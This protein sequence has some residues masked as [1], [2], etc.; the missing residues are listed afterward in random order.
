[1]SSSRLDDSTVTIPPPRRILSV[2]K[3]DA[4]YQAIRTDI[5]EGRL[6]PGERLR[7]GSLI[8]RLGMSPTP[9]RE[10]LRLL[11]AH[12]LV[13]N[14][15]HHGM[16]VKEYSVA[17]VEEIYDLRVVLEPLA[18]KFAA[19]RAEAADLDEIRRLHDV[20]RQAARKEPYN[21]AALNAQWHRRIYAASR[22]VYHQE[23]IE[24]LWR[25]LPVEVVWAGAR[26][27]RALS[28]HQ[29]IMEALEEHD[30]ER[31]A[32]L[33]KEHIEAG[34]GTI[35]ERLR[36]LQGPAPAGESA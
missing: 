12:G 31:A 32:A 18:A 28:E 2:T 23:F 10:A 17:G 21:M 26:R 8:E 29:A 16:I 4:A 22:S 11:Q 3:T 13:E 20:L 15:P 9:I 36:G 7:I 33:M 14:R 35:A 27:D 5:E 34:M 30:G 19:E 25:A 1:V 6:K 24:R